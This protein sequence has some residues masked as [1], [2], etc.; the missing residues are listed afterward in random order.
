MILSLR[1]R[2]LLGFPTPCHPER[3]GF[4]GPSEGKFVGSS[5]MKDLHF[6][7]KPFAAR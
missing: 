1:G 2:A 6:G 7:S 4:R 3:S 5:E